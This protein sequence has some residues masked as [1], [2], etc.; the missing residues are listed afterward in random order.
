MMSD[1]VQEGGAANVGAPGAPA[2]AS[3]DPSVLSG[4]GVTQNPDN[5]AAVFDLS[6]VA[7]ENARLR[8]QLIEENERLKAALA[9]S[10]ASGLALTGLGDEDVR[11]IE[12]PEEYVDEY[13]ALGEHEA[14]TALVGSLAQRLDAAE[15][16]NANAANERAQ[17][18]AQPAQ[19]AP[20]ESVGVT[21]DPV[22]D[23]S[24]Q[25]T[26]TDVSEPHT[27]AIVG[28]EPAIVADSQGV[29]LSTLTDSQLA[30]ELAR[31]ESAGSAS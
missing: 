21:A 23:S 16:A 24:Q 19:P 27:G 2:V 29:D 18:A 25:F 3:N 13:A 7:E 30:D 1:V 17:L 4:P 6:A 22:T 14:L 11:R 12:H 9:D 26:G 8:A 15:R 10:R 5:A 20:R 31:R 28:D